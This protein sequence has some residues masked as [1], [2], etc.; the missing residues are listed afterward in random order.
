MSLLTPTTK[1]RTQIVAAQTALSKQQA[2]DTYQH[3]VRRYNL[4]YDTAWHNPNIAD[5][6]EAQEYL[7]NLGPGV[8][9]EAF[10][11]NFQL[12]TFL[13]AVAPG[14]VTPARMAPPV[15][16]TAEPIEVTPQVGVEGDENYEPAVFGYRIVLDPAATYPGPLPS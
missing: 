15:G 4:Q 7:D 14:T 8:A 6:T 1:T 10:Q 13:N 11:A 12:A 3:C 5:I 2:I 16:Y 9:A